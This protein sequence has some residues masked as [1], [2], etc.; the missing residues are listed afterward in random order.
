M[1]WLYAV[2]IVVTSDFET[3]NSEVMCSCHLFVKI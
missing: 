1:Q 3:T 2:K